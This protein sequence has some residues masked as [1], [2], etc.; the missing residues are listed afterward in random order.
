MLSSGKSQPPFSPPTSKFSYEDMINC[1]VLRV[2][3]FVFFGLAIFWGL[4]YS[5]NFPDDPISNDYEDKIAELEAYLLKN[6]QVEVPRMVPEKEE[7]S[8]HHL[9]TLVLIDNQLGKLSAGHK[10]KELIKTLKI[11]IHFIQ[12][13]LFV[14]PSSCPTKM[15]N[16]TTLL[17]NLT[18]S[19]YFLKKHIKENFT[20]CLNVKCKTDENVSTM[21]SIIE[22]KESNQQSSTVDDGLSEEQEHT[23]STLNSD[24][25]LLD[26]IVD[27]LKKSSARPHV[28]TII[29]FLLI[30]LAV[31]IMVLLFA[32]WKRRCICQKDNSIT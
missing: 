28:P 10:L 8:C 21:K 29:S 16:L 26:R 13:C 22:T 30:P 14:I 15:V 23:T 7:E 27:P 17:Q 9:L 19:L 3:G 4:G 1:H 32:C 25:S 31:S 12:D 18:E 11:E 24:G 6:Y 20:H 5:C 2:K